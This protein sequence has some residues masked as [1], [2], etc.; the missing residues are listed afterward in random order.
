MGC[1]TG[2]VTMRTCP[3]LSLDEAVEDIGQLDSTQTVSSSGSAARFCK[4]IQSLPALLSK[5]IPFTV[6]ALQ[7]TPG[8]CNQVESV[9][10]HT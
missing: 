6:L 5:V 4:A 3:L 2:R 9:M 7:F 10:P 8:I 1:R